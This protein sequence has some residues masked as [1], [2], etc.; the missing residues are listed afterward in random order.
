MHHNEYPNEYYNE[1]NNESAHSKSNSTNSINNSTNKS[2]NNS[3][4]NPINDLTNSDSSLLLPFESVE[5]ETIV[6]C[7]ALTS[8]AFGKRPE[9]RSVQELLDFGVVNIDKPAGPTSH[10][11]SAYVQDILNIQK[12]GHSGTLDPGVTGVLPVALGRATRTL[13]ALL[14]AGKEYVGVMHLHEHVEQA[15][16]EQAFDKFTGEISQLPPI[17]SSVKRQTR[18]R[19]I[20]YL[21]ILEIQ[22]KDVLFITGVQAGT[23]IRK[24]CHDIGLELGVGAHMAELRRT[25][26]GPFKEN[27]E[28]SAKGKNGAACSIYLQDLAD[29]Y[30]FWKNEGKEAPLRKCIQHAEACIQHLPKIWVLDTT[31]ESLCHGAQLG[32]PGIAK[33]ETEIVKGD[34]VA[35]LSLKNELIALAI[36]QMDSEGMRADKGIAASP[37]AVLMQPG[38]Y[39]KASRTVDTAGS[40]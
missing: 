29:A 38:T 24:L 30:W 15:K 7:D 13:S 23:Y 34:T 36:A 20:Y 25:K 26:A 14:S 11:V 4:S 27:S 33:F 2:T 12:S 17:R 21:K 18:Q 40:S 1:Y 19:S 3:T 16:I 10:Q 9:Q 8:Y 28:N 6:R 31:V 35:I 32:L 22:E 39:P 5:R 37:N